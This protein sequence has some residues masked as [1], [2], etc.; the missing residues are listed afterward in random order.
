MD[1][2]QRRKYNS[3]AV[4]TR[5]LLLGKH[6]PVQ[7]AIRGVHGPLLREVTTALA[8]KAL[9]QHEAEEPVDVGRLARR[10]Q[11]VGAAIR[12]E[13]ALVQRVQQTPT[14]LC[15]VVLPAARKSVQY[16]GSPLSNSRPPSERRS[17]G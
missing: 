13:L 9:L 4:H 1:G 17:T 15:S 2:A 11:P 10:A 14:E 16:G 6:R 12:G 3:V 8:A 7:H 5:A